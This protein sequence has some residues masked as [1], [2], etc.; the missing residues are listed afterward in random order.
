MLEILRTGGWL[1]RQRLLTYPAIL[2]ALFTIAGIALLA[3]SHAGR[4]AYGRPLGT[5]FSAVWTAGREVNRGQPARPYDVA[6]YRSDQEKLFGASD[7]FYIW[8][9]PPYSLAVA[10]IL[11]HLPYAAAF[12]LWQGIM[13]ALYLG[14][15]FAA[16]RQARVATSAVLI[17]ALA[18]PAVF[19]NLMHGQNGFLTAALLGGALIF[20]SDR[21][22]LAGLG[23][24]LLAY[25]PHFALLIVPA[26]LAGG[27]WRTM[28]AAV[29]G[30]AIM[31]L[32]SLFAFGAAPW[33]G[34]FADLS[35]TRA[36]L[37]QGAAGFAK[38]QSP[39]ASLRLLGG[40][41]AFAY[42]VQG[43]VSAV[44]LIVIALLWRS[45]AD[46]RLKAAALLAAS[47][48]ATPYGFDYDMVVLGP[49]LAFAVS[50]GLEKGFR[51][52]EKSG[53]ALVWIAPLFARPVA[54]ALLIPLGPLVIA[55]FL[56]GLILRA[57][58]DGLDIREPDTAKVPLRFG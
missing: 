15:V 2:L 1:T 24:A 31:T 52:Y 29:T 33:H 55:L 44:L 7:E 34:F 42:A 35:F 13:L 23:F 19:I 43:I 49:A 32:A 20:L 12:L 48:I 50:Y 9:Y 41:V 38:L 11:A 53:L 4:D 47:L 3:T 45:A 37:E 25:K 28:A 40:G 36:M 46:F 14:V 26:L 27:R 17:A 21:P 30:L 10:S 39:F 54:G 57:R 56:G 6:A 18:Y 8:P 16:L 22:L 51:A 58:A 5:D